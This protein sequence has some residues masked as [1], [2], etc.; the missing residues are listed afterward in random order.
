[1]F[2]RFILRGITGLCRA[3]L[4]QNLDSS[5]YKEGTIHGG[6]CE[7]WIRKFGSRDEKSLRLSIADTL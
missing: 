5:I 6:P 1:M 7:F 4:R 3:G 2:D